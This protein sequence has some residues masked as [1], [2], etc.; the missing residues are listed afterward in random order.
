MPQSEDQEGDFQESIV[1]F[2]KHLADKKEA[3][4]E[5]F[6]ELKGDLKEKFQQWKETS[7]TKQQANQEG[8]QQFSQQLKELLKEKFQQWKETFT[9]KQQT[10]KDD[11]KEPSQQLKE[12]LKEKFQQWKEAFAAKQEAA[13]DNAGDKQ[14]GEVDEIKLN[15]LFQLFLEF[16]SRF[17]E[18]K[19]ALELH[20]SKQDTKR[21]FI[22]IF[23]GFMQDLQEI[24]GQA[25]IAH[26]MKEKVEASQ[27]QRQIEDEVENWEAKF[28]EFA[29]VN[30]LYIANV[31]VLRDVTNVIVLRDLTFTNVM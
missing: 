13:Q 2:F 8:D 3:A 14:D 1:K 6:Q 19:Q 29:Q 30:T 25:K 26:V 21:L 5:P 15:A 17:L 12:Q 7:A 11:D 24:G 9:K 16:E 28:Q 18:Q 22:E 4:Q 31:I 20:L 10:D 23:L 27:K